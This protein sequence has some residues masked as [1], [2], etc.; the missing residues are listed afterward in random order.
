MFNKRQSLL[1]DVRILWRHDFVWICFIYILIHLTF[2]SWY[3]QLLSGYFSFLLVLYYFVT[4]AI[5]PNVYI[6]NLLNDTCDSVPISS[7]V[8]LDHIRIPG[9]LQRFSLTYLVIALMELV[10]AR[11][12]DS[13]QVT[14]SREKLVKL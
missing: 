3:F 10:C 13:H 9:V 11:K 12:K 2:Y 7:A 5:D 14:I 6:S 1:Y 4:V 8:D